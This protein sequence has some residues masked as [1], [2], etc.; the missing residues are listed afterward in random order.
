MIEHIVGIRFAPHDPLVFC[1]SDLP[2]LAIGQRVVV[3]INGARREADVAVAPTTIV[4]APPLHG[5]P[6]IVAIAEMAAAMPSGD[7]PDDIDFLP[8]DDSAIGTAA[9]IEALRL[10]AL[11]IPPTPEARR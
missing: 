11:P 7:L 8:A 4:A 9:V 10:A 5:A 2:D 6:R 1:V 3:E